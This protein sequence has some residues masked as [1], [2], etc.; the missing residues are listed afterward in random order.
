MADEHLTKLKALEG[1]VKLT[2]KSLVKQLEF[3]REIEDFL[4]DHKLIVESIGPFYKL[5]GNIKPVMEEKEE[6]VLEVE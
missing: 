6:P 4:A 2:I 1:Q 3:W 5:M